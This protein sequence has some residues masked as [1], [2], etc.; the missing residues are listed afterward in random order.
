MLVVHGV[1]GRYHHVP[2]MRKIY[3]DR[4][5]VQGGLVGI[6]LSDTTFHSDGFRARRTPLRNEQCSYYWTFGS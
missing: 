4:E 3:Q 2:G 5:V 6:C 1:C